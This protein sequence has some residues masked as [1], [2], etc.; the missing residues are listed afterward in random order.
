M[1]ALQ[2][3]VVDDDSAHRL[4]LR[5]EL[6]SVSADLHIEEAATVKSASECLTDGSYDGV[7]TDF[8]LPDGDA[9]NVFEAARKRSTGTPV[10]VLTAFAEPELQARLMDAGVV[11]CLD[12]LATSGEALL[13]TLR[14]GSEPTGQELAAGPWGLPAD[15]DPTPRDTMQQTREP[16]LGLSDSGASPVRFLLVED[17][18]VAIMGVRRAFKKL[19]IVNSLQV[20]SDASEALDLLRG[21]LAG[22]QPGLER[23]VLLDLNL[24]GMSGLEFLAQL[25]REPSLV[26]TS[27][28]IFTTSS[29]G[30]DRRACR[31]LGAVRYVVKSDFERNVS[32]AIGWLRAEE[33]APSPGARASTVRR[34]YLS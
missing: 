23:V 9:F 34:L 3:L 8:R 28:V 6:Q 25:R 13:S 5:R 15:T 14:L 10:V 26:E 21:E 31:Q 2:L 32:E 12:K 27:V 4:I 19:G 11:A 24:P 7:V 22:G 18:Q 1:S 20:T 29:R 30:E 17:D 33:L 16:A